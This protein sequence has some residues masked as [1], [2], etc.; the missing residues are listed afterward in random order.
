MDIHVFRD[1]LY[2]GGAIGTTFK[3]WKF[4]LSIFF[5]QKPSKMQIINV[6]LNTMQCMEGSVR[7]CNKEKTIETCLKDH[8]ILLQNVF[9]VSLVSLM[10]ASYVFDLYFVF[11]LAFI[12]M[13]TI[14]IFF[15]NDEK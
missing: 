7:I 15:F 6:C 14:M 12:L 4:F 2:E 13:I 9:F 1:F 8:K 3:T 5:L 10:C 11:L